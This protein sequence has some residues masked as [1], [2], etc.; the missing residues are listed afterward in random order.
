MLPHC[1]FTSLVVTRMKVGPSLYLKFQVV[2]VK[3]QCSR[4]GTSKE[5]SKAY[6]TDCGSKS[7]QLEVGRAEISVPVQLES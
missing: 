1:N 2:W 6:G 5:P 3:I 7:Q 4:M